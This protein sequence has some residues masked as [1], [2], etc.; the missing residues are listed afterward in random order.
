MQNK[1]DRETSIWGAA[2]FSDVIAN[3]ETKNWTC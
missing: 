3:C 2:F 1:V